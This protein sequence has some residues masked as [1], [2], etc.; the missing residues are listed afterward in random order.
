MKR[1]IVLAV[2]LL[3]TCGLVGCSLN[4]DSDQKKINLIDLVN[5]LI[6]NEEVIKESDNYYNPKE[7]SLLKNNKEGIIAISIYDF[8]NDKED[9]V[10]I[11][12][13]KDDNVELTLYELEDNK[14]TEKDKT[15]LLDDSF[16]YADTIDMNGF[17]KNID[18]TSYL[19]YE[20]VLNSSLVADGITWEFS[21]IDIENGKFNRILDNKTSGSYF[22]EEYIDNIKDFVEDA[23][24]KIDNFWFYENGESLYEQNKDNSYL[25]YEINRI[26]L[27]S[28]NEE[29]YYSSNE[30]KVLYGKTIYKDLSNNYKIGA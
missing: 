24:L 18:N 29:L 13:E 8:D 6:K 11:T 3:L 7:Y 28:F 23:S 12:R 4:S 10:I 14:L 1:K 26:H 22:D 21:K 27:D 30:T 16:S 2:I 25:M 17:V 15:K 20:S 5:D 19:F 9:E